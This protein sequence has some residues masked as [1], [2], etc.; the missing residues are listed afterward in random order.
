MIAEPS[1]REIASKYFSLQRT[2]R[3]HREHRV[4]CFLGM[5]LKVSEIRTSAEKVDMNRDK[6]QR[7]IAKTSVF[8][9]LPPFLCGEILWI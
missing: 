6:T 9:V 1:I 4:F 3:I 8:S 5:I 7:M 2:Q